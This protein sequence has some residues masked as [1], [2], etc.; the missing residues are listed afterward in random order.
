MEKSATSLPSIRKV[1]TNIK[2]RIRQAASL[3]LSGIVW[4]A[5]D[6]P[7]EFVIIGRHVMKVLGIDN[8]NILTAEY[9]KFKGMV[10]IQEQL[11]TKQG[12]NGNADGSGKVTAY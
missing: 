4:N 2:I 12:Q 10:N 7:V 1:K 3:V 11:L 9:E 6:R 5:R 8:R